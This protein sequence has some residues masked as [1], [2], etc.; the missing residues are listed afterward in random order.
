MSS[1]SGLPSCVQRTVSRDIKLYT[2]SIGRG[3]F[4]NVYLG[5]WRDQKVAVKTC[6]SSSNGFFENELLILDMLRHKNILRLIAADNM[7]KSDCIEKWLI[8]DYHEHGSLYDYL[9]T[10]TVTLRTALNMCVSLSDGLAYFHMPIDACKSKSPLAHCDFKSQNVLVKRN[11]TC[12]ISDFGLSLVGTSDDRVRI[13]GG[14][15]GK[16]FEL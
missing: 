13:Q 12:C 7:G 9:Q 16:F 14:Y 10:N 2:Q 5:V 11:L 8:I 15:L 4:G 3:R 6:W 1:D